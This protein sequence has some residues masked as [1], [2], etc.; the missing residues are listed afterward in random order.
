MNRAWS[1]TNPAAAALAGVGLVG[2][3]GPL[4][5]DPGIEPYGNDSIKPLPA[6]ARTAGKAADG[7]ASTRQAEGAGMM[8]RSGTAQRWRICASGIV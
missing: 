6:R 2:S 4:D 1:F 3:V 8:L 5:V 7:D